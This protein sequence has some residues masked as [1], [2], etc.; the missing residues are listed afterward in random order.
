MLRVIKNI[1]LSRIEHAIGVGLRSG[2]GDAW[3]RIGGIKMFA[4]GALGPQ[5]AAM[6]KPYEND[7]GNYG[8]VVIDKEEMQTAAT[9]AS[10]HGLS[11]TVHAIGDRANHDVL[12]VFAAVRQEEKER[13]G[14]RQLRHRIEHVQ[15][16]HPTD[17]DRLAQLNI[18]ASM[19]PIHATSDMEM[20]TAHWG[21]RTRYSYAWRTML[22][23]GAVLAFGSD[24]PV[25]RIDPLLGIH[26]GVTRQTAAGAPGKEGW[27]PEQKLSLS[28]AIHAFTL[29]PAF[30]AGQEGVLGSITPGKLADLTIFDRDIFVLPPSELLHTQI[31]GTIING[32]FRYRTW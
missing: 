29:A 14:R 19:Q 23:S 20:A 16:L 21:E 5:T 32:D 1:P 8:I 25:E 12:D 4:D 24:A 13:A 6:V 11:V 3:L 26:A 30:A 9:L 27:H 7:P 2:F 22:D 10:A 31:A 28:E 15:L 18:I 17:L